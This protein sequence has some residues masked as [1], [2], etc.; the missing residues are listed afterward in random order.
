[1]VD[2]EEVGYKKYALVIV[3]GVFI[4]DVHFRI[5]NP[6]ELIPVLTILNWFRF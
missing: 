2:N 4:R 5:S 1:M 6:M 3:A